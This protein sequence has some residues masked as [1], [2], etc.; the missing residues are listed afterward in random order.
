MVNTY[1]RLLRD[2]GR[3]DDEEYYIIPTV[4]KFSF[5]PVFKHTFHLPQFFFF[6]FCFLSLG[7]FYSFLFLMPLNLFHSTE[8]CYY[9]IPSYG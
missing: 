7:A 2:N 3:V 6:C 8:P 5:S 1:S 9:C 4:E